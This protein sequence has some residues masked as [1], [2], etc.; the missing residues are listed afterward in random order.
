MIIYNP[1]LS[2]LPLLPHS[3]FSL[4]TPLQI[5]TATIHCPSEFARKGQLIPLLYLAGIKLLPTAGT[6]AV[7]AQGLPHLAFWLAGVGVTLVKLIPLSCKDANATGPQTPSNPPTHSQIK[8]ENCAS[9][10]SAVWPGEL[11]HSVQ[12]HHITHK[13]PL[14][15]LSKLPPQGGCWKSRGNKCC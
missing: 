5:T 12:Y 15:F 8:L 6:P 13:H 3:T 10:P 4:F 1:A 14:F 2:N 9:V 7:Q 11:Q